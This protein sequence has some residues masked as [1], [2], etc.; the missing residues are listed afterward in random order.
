MQ[1][2][3]ALRKSQE[4]VEKLRA[5]LRK[6]D[7]INLDEVKAMIEAEKQR[8]QKELEDKQQWDA[9][10]AQMVEE[11]NKVLATLKQENEALK[12]QIGQRDNLVNE[13]TV[14]RSFDASKFI[15]EELLLTPAKARQIYGGHFDIENGQVVA[16]DKPRGVEGRVQLIDGSGNP[17]SFEDALK[18]IVDQDP[19]RDRLLRSKMKP[20]SGSNTNNQAPGK[21]KA[22]LRGVDRIV[23]ALE[24]A[25][26][27]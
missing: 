6:F 19:D 14:G 16:Y 20:G 3:E 10:K 23:A 8:K 13:L 24:K 27:K 21:P 9:L 5:D 15:N 18:K 1:K 4:E 12:A 26:K 11:H 17:L 2:K 7:G 22:E 25:G